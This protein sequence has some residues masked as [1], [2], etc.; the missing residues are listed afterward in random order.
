[1]MSY[2]FRSLG[3]CEVLRRAQRVHRELDVRISYHNVFAH[4]I[5]AVFFPGNIEVRAGL[6]T[7]RQKRGHFCGAGPVFAMVSCACDMTLH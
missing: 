2:T 4:I 7:T 3:D 1:M 5:C 6:G